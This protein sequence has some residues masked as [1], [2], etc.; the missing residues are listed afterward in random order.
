M[1]LT[2]EEQASIEARFETIEEQIR[3]L[4][5][6]GN[7]DP[8]IPLLATG[9]DVED[10]IFNSLVLI[11]STTLSAA[12]VTLAD[13]TSIPAEFKNLKIIYNGKAAS[14]GS[15]LRNVS[16]RFNNDSGANY[17]TERDEDG[18]HTQNLG[19]NRALVNKLDGTTTGGPAWGEFVVAS[20]TSTAL[21]KGIT[22]HGGYVIPLDIVDYTSVCNWIISPRVAIDRVTIFS[23]AGTA[24]F[25]T[26]SEAYLYGF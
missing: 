20:Y 7:L 5:R 19:L 26:G 2:P 4:K 25:D 13:F 24:E 15:V 8:R 14:G 23:D 12:S 1:V 18:T 6:K 3:R 17:H 21:P 16:V 22:N 11:A 10:A 9:F